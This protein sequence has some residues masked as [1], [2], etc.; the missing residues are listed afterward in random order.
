MRG[1]VFFSRSGSIIFSVEAT[2]LSAGNTRLEAVLYGIFEV[3]ERHAVSQ[4]LA[5]KPF[6]VLDASSIHGPEIH[7]LFKRLDELGAQW[8][9]FDLS[10]LAPFPC[11][12]V[13]LLYLD[14]HTPPV[15]VAGQGC[16]ISSIVALKR[17]LSE[18]IQSHT[19]AIQGNRED[20]IRHQG[21]WENEEADVIASWHEAKQE[22]EKHGLSQL[23]SETD[24]CKNMFELCT[25]ACEQLFDQG[26]V[27]IMVTDL[28][29]PNIE[30]PVVHVLIPGMVDQTTNEHQEFTNPLTTLY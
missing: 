22:A 18:A 26:Y 12:F 21:E 8:C 7:A 4:F 20:L 17:A 19:V 27:N 16:H 23:Q 24:S 28:T 13:S 15:M 29:V 9:I 25:Y 6:H 30:I 3:V 2:G 5:E 1:S 11:F 14:A 10:S